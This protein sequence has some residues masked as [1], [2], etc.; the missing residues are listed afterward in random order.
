MSLP[1][2][3]RLLERAKADLA[4]DADLDDDDVPAVDLLASKSLEMA[5]LLNGCERGLVAGYELA[6]ITNFDMTAEKIA[7]ILARL[8][9]FDR[10][11]G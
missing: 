7:D 9:D 11:I 5:E 1:N 4:T 3:S 2:L 6:R 10:S 8:A